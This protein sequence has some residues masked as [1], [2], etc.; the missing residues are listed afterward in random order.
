M[1][2]QI[3]RFPRAMKRGPKVKNGPVAAIKMF[4]ERAPWMA[5]TLQARLARFLAAKYNKEDRA[6]AA[7]DSMRYA[8]GLVE[9]GYTDGRLE[10]GICNR[11]RR[12]KDELA[13][14][15]NL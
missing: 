4:P 2:A 7:M 14:L 11:I 15:E 5:N 3:T 8:E 1:S 12:L 6:E 10:E 9:A 13:E